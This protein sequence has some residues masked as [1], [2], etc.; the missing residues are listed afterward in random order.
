MNPES[1][2]EVSGRMAALELI[3]T[4]A[5]GMGL[6]PLR[7][8][9]D[10]VEEWRLQFHAKLDRLPAEIKPHAVSA[11]DRLLFAA[12]ARAEEFVK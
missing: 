3:V 5:L 9:A 8:R 11:S 1:N 2:T 7:N 12:L 10:L 4:Q 6:V